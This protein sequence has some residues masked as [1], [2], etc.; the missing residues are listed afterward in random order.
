MV[1]RHQD[2]LLQELRQEVA[3]LRNRQG[4]FNQLKEQIAYLQDKSHQTSSDKN[5][6]DQECA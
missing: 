5:R 6:S 3:E 4:D 1:E 2:L